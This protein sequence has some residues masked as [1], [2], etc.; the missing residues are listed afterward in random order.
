MKNAYVEECDVE[1]QL[2]TGWHLGTYDHE[3]AYLPS[4]LSLNFDRLLDIQIW[5]ILDIYVYILK[6]KHF[7]NYE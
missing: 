3:C 7:N 5:L 2:S 4:T 1:A 6:Y